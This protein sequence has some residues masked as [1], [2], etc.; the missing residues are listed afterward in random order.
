MYEETPDRIVP[1]EVR[2]NNMHDWCVD[3]KL[4]P[5]EYMEEIAHSERYQVEVWDKLFF[6]GNPPREPVRSRVI[7]NY[8][9]RLISKMFGRQAAHD[10]IWMFYKEHFNI[11][12]YR[13]PCC[14][15]VE[16]LNEI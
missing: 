1:C 6:N 15:V 13:C 10:W 5:G 12:A 2:H 11:P 14:G 9:F 16:I 8:Q 4:Y 3:K 7:T